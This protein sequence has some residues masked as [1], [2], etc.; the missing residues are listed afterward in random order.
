MAIVVKPL[1]PN[2]FDDGL[3]LARLGHAPFDE[4]AWHEELEALSGDAIQGGAL[5]AR[6]S[7]GR[8]C[9]LILYRILAVPGAG[10]SLEIL[11]LVAFDLM[12]PQPIADALVHET[13]QLARLQGCETLR[14][15][16]RLTTPADTI[17]AV[18][19]VGVTELHSVF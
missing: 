12:N 7:M 1:E 8:V 19:A 5:L 6:N 15:V 9:G 4:A 3:V 16:R 14:T 13:F 18:L 10:P 2:E 11:R 17:A